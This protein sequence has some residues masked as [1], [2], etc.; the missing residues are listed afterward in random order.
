MSQDHRETA[1]DSAE[2][3]LVMAV[4]VERDVFVL[5]RTAKDCAEAAG[6]ENQDRV[7]LATALSEL[8]RDLLRPQPLRAVFAL[9]HRELAVSLDWTDARTPGAETLAA[10]ARLL[11]QVRWEPAGGGRPGGSVVIAW[12]LPGSPE[13]VADRAARIRAALRSVAGSGDSLTEDL[14]AQTLDLMAALEESRRQQEALHLLNQE[15]EQTNQGVVALY[16]ELS[17][18][19]EET[20][21]GVVALY[22]ELD[23]KSRLLREASESKTRFWSNVS[24]ELRTPLNSVIGLS[25]LLL[26]PAAEPLTAEQRRQVALVGSAGSMLLVLVDEL[27]DV[28]KA[29]A[30]RLEPRPAPVDLRALL[31]QVRGLM[32]GAAPRGEVALVVP[33]REDLPELLTDE[34]ML[35]RILRN[36][37]SNG[38]KFTRSGEVRLEVGTEDEWLVLVVSDTGVGIPEDQQTRV[39]EEFY[40]VPGPHQRNRAG[41]GLGL[42]YAR[43]L[44]ELLGGSLQLASRPGQGTTVTLRLPLRTVDAPAPVRRLGTLLTVDDD[45]VFAELFRPVLEQLA[46]RVVQ[47]HE[48]ARVVAEVRRL[49]P[50]AVLL[51]LQMPGT[52]GYAVLAELSAD[53]ELSTVPVVVITAADQA[54]RATERLGHARAV[55]SKHG[56]TAARLADILYP[57]VRAGT[58]P[59][60]DEGQRS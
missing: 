52:D 46:E 44:A 31:A 23:E 40:Q 20:N 45:P 39:F 48:G 37:L 11:P 3:L 41:T 14:R 35:A 16:T 18:E 4:G 6:L 58:P 15:L 38:L 30:G 43:R 59:D 13:P 55:L 49:R 19:L 5:R 17:E 10:V 60:A 56:A 24:H 9:G 28:A 36:L 2:T 27:L 57:A 34:V 26:D 1:A 53:P 7:R 54:E 21:R 25:R 8:G 29:E 51:D 33:D 50:D 22:A 47:V 42:P 32:V 12:P